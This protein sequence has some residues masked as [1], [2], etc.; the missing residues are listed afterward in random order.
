MLTS[1]EVAYFETCG[2]LVLRKLFSAA[3]V[4]RIKLDYGDAWNQAAGGQ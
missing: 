1:G 3:E 4:K 2:F